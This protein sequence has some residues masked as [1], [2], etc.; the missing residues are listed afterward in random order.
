VAHYLFI[1]GNC[2]FVK[3]QLP[4]LL[5]RSLGVIAAIG[6]DAGRRFGSAPHFEGSSAFSIARNAAAPG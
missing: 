4:E 5:E 3:G 6:I 2:L 1:K